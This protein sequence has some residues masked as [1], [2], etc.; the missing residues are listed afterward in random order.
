MCGHARRDVGR[1]TDVERAVAPAREDVNIS[2]ALR[3]LIKLHPTKP[4]HG[5]AW[6]SH[7]VAARLR[8]GRLFK[9]GLGGRAKPDHGE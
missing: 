8:G 5:W 9:S 7:P 3:H 6:P 4:H 2:A 1:D